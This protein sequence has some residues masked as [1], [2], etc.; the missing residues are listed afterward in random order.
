[1]QNP[2]R[3]NEW[4]LCALSICTLRLHYSSI[5]AIDLSTEVLAEREASA[6]VMGNILQ[7]SF[8]ARN[9]HADDCHGFDVGVVGRSGPE[10]P[11]V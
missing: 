2:P 7:P 3:K 11:S 5:L 8:I 1:M 4:G 10:R 9:L 6:K